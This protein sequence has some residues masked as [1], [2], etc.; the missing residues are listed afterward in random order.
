MRAQT[1][2]KPPMPEIY[3]EEHFMI[4][5]QAVRKINVRDYTYQGALEASEKINW[6]IE[7]II[8]G[9]KRL[10]FSRPFMPES[11]ART[12]QLNFLTPFERLKLNQIRGHAYLSIFGLVEEFI[13]PFVLDHARP[14]LSQDDHRT[15]AF[16]KF[17]G[18]EAQHIHLFKQFRDEFRRGFGVD[19]A[20][21]GPPEAI[22]GAIL[23][24]DPS[25]NCF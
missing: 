9:N 8:G 3:M 2:D 12:N 25:L 6:R 24:H 19:C 17:A 13:L 1:A 4:A 11:L 10:D 22:A 15:R 16:L 18:E 14:N 7:D 5:I 20:V 21:I 23:A